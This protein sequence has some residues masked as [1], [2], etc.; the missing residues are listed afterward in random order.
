MALC[1]WPAWLMAASPLVLA[2]PQ[3][4]FDSGWRGA[5]ADARWHEQFTRTSRNVQLIRVRAEDADV[6]VRLA[7]DS[8]AALDANAPGGR[9]GREFLCLDATK[10]PGTWH[11]EVSPEQGVARARARIEVIELGRLGPSAAAICNALAAATQQAEPGTAAAEKNVALVRRAASQL[12]DRG[13]LLLAGDAWL[14]ASQLDYAVLSNWSRSADS[15]QHALQAFAAAHADSER[16]DALFALGGANIELAKERSVEAAAFALRKRRVAAARVALS[17]ARRLFKS[18]H[19]PRAAARASNDL[20]MSFFYEAEF[21]AA[22]RAFAAARAEAN[23][24]QDR[25]LM[26]LVNANLATVLSKHGEPQRAAEAFNELLNGLPENSRVDLRLTALHNSANPYLDLGDFDAALQRYLRALDLSRS[27]GD[28]AAEARALQGIGR[29]YHELGED[30]RA[31]SFLQHALQIR[32]RTGDSG[33]TLSVLVI[34]GEVRRTQGDL[35]AARLLHE[36]AAA[37]PAAPAEAAKARLALSLDF[38]ALGDGA[39]SLR[40]L[41][42]LAALAIDELHPYRLAARLQRASSLRLLGRNQ[43]AIAEAA[44]VAATFGKR[45]LVSS[46]IAARV[47][48]QRALRAAG[49]YPAAM[50]A[51]R[52]TAAL[53][54]RS[55][56]AA[57]S[58][59]IRLRYRAS[60]EAIYQEWVAAVLAYAAQQQQAGRREAA[61]QS[62]R[63]ALAAANSG[64]AHELQ[65]ARAAAPQPTPA[66]SAELQ[67][68]YAQL[69]GRFA[70]L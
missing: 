64:R 8:S 69:A 7:T 10:A 22:E 14:A 41:D 34:L 11:I 60:R 52:Q 6:T 51:G 49:D 17:E 33:G 9:W 19:R 24:L 54:E 12:T 15:A 59:A 16:A 5:A 38:I 58:D 55:W 32:Q 68:R 36:Q 27:S 61:Q 40:Q 39:A 3:P 35:Q 66:M 28:S 37:V 42:T 45:H 62:F 63:E 29:T 47:E 26:Q 53:F 25:T 48:L 31:A 20:A 67:G 65:G 18:L 2:A 43:E 30:Q 21:A 13:E 4:A 70:A 23:N 1:R 56:L 50:Q 57:G 44:A 46:Q